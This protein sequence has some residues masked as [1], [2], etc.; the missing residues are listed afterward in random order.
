[1][2]NFFPD[3][4]LWNIRIGS[5]IDESYLGGGSYGEI[6]K[7]IEKLD[8]KDPQSWE[9]EFL[10]M[11]D[12]VRALAENAE[13]EGIRQVAQDR[14]LRASNYYMFALM[15]MHHDDLEM[16]L[17][18][19]KRS[20]ECFH[21]GIE[22]APNIEPVKVPYEDSYLSGYFVNASQ[23]G[24]KRPVVVIVDGTE[25]PAEKMFF[26]IGRECPKYGFSALCMDGPGNGGAIRLN[27]LHSRYDSEV[28]A[29]AFFDYLETRADVDEQRVALASPSLGGYFAPR[30]VAFEKRY[31]ACI[32]YGAAFEMARRPFEERPIHTLKHI[33][34]FMGVDS[35]A[36]LTEKAAN[37]NL[38]EV[39]PL[40]ECPTLI[41][42]G[43]DD[44]IVPLDE[45]YE[46]YEALRCPKKLKIF[47]KEDGGEQHCQAGNKVL[48]REEIFSWLI[49]T[50][51]MTSA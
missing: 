6:V 20:V 3:N 12:K 37:Y 44:H 38:R 14:Y 23:K 35:V 48:A 24:E 34:W 30:A 16:E 50:F 49:S 18:I 36:A 19:Y 17:D 4:F 31:A 2:Y 45:A 33:M 11:G 47:T 25:G 40:V 1:M 32:I 8:T 39:A 28:Q 13:A 10:A 21:R 41:L 29:K 27:G 5:I 46:T 43:E 42:H 26:L 22:G 9:R 51:S 7:V 15:L